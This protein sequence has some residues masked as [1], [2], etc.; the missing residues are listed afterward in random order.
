MPL[1]LPVTNAHRGQPLEVCVRPAD[2]SGTE[3][4]HVKIQFQSASTAAFKTLSTLAVTNP[5]GYFDVKLTLPSSG[6]VQTAWT[7]PG[8]PTIHSRPVSITGS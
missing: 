1:Y 4:T 7:Y 6:T 8:G 3:P 2:N 5:H